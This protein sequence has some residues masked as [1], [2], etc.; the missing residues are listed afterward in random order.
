MSKY[1]WDFT[2]PE[3]VLKTQEMLNRLS[4]P[5]LAMSDAWKVEIP[6]Y[7]FSGAYAALNAY[8][9]NY[10]SISRQI[11]QMDSVLKSVRPMIDT[12]VYATL[13]D[14]PALK[15]ALTSVD[16]SWLSEVYTEDDNDEDADDIEAP[17]EEKLDPEIR[18]QFAADIT[19]VLAKPESMHITSQNKYLQWLRESPEH[20]LQFL[21]TLLTIIGT[22]IAA[23]SLSVSMR[24]ARLTKDSQVYQAPSS[25]SNV[26]YNVTI[27]NSITVIGDEP[28]YYE[29][30]FIHPETGEKVT[31]YIYK[32]NVVIEEPDEPEASGEEAE[33]VEESEPIVD[34]TDTQTDSV[35]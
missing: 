21:N 22:I 28:Y 26:V 20:A 19:E 34:E 7:D 23:V 11:D 18:A 27:E 14:A 4:A 10:D 24:Q 1:S 3:S 35:G 30:E 13:L 15:A 2:L 33:V 12:S 17:A 29:I 25:T 8:L 32:G 5:A 6:Q 9:D 16:W 31:G